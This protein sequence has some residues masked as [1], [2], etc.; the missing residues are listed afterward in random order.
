MRATC[1]AGRLGLAVQAYQKRALPV[2]AWLAAI[3]A[4]AGSPHSG[5][6]RQR[7]LLGH[8][9]QARAGTGPRRLSRFS[10]AKAATDA[11]YL[12]CARAMLAAARGDLSA[13]RHAQRA[14]AFGRTGLR[15]RAHGFRISAPAWHGRSAVRAVSRSETAGT[16]AAPAC[17]SMRRWARM[18]ICSPISC[19]GCSRTAPTPRSSTGWPT[20]KRPSPRS[21][22]IR[23]SSSGGA[24]APPQRAH[25]QAGGYVCRTGRIRAGFLWGDPAVARRRSPRCTHSSRSPQRRCFVAMVP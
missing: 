15:R 21:S 25:S 24:A 23:S 14:H 11:S 9:D 1:A 7:R 8:G 19:A 16:C 5:A 2:I 22:P 18:R 4:R 17:A 20:R 6:A 10:R 3:G 12:A 13:I